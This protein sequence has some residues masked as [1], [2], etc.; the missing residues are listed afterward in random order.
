MGK[1]P[2]GPMTTDALGNTVSVAELAERAEAEAARAAARARREAKALAAS[3]DDRPSP[4][5][6]PAAASSSPAAA[7]AAVVSLEDQLRALVLKLDAGEKL[8]GKEKRLHAK[9][10]KDGRLP[11]VDEARRHLDDDDAAS[12]PCSSSSSSARKKKPPAALS[13]PEKWARALEAVSVHVRSGG[14]GDEDHPADVRSG[15][16]AA[17][18]VSGLDVSVRGVTLFDDAAFKILRGQKLALL[19]ANGSGKSTLVRL[20][21]AGRIRAHVA[22]VACVAQELEASDRSAFEA[23]VSCDPAAEALFEEERTIEREMEE[24][25]KLDV[26]GEEDGGPDEGD[27]AGG[28]GDT[29]TTTAPTTPPTTPPTF[30]SVGWWRLKASRLAEIGDAL[31]SR[32]AYAAESNARR[33]L[34]GLG[35]DDARQDAPLRSLS[36]GWRMRA[37][38]ATALFLKPGLL[39]LDEP[40]NHLDLP[41]TLWLARYLSSS[42]ETK[43]TS[44]LIVSHS[45]DFVAGCGAEVLFLDKFS[46]KITKHAGD[47]WNFLN[48]AEERHRLALKRYEAQ[49][50]QLREVQKKH[51]GLS[52]ERAAAKLTDTA[53]AGGG[54]KKHKGD[55]SDSG[56]GGSSLLEKPRE[57]AVSFHFPGAGDDR[58]TIAVLDAGFAGYDSD[59]AADS[60]SAATKKVGWMFRDLRFSVHSR[61]RLA[62]VGPNGCG[63]STLINLL[64]GK[65]APTSGEITHGRGLVV[66]R[67]DQHF[68]D[69]LGV[70]SDGDGSSTTTTDPPHPMSRPGGR[71]SATSFLENTFA[72]STQDAR[73]LLGRSGLESESHLAPL[74][75]LSGGQKARVVFA[76]LAA[77]RAHVLVMDEP[78]NHLD[79][80]SV[81]ALVEGLNAFEG[82]VVVSTHDPRVVEGME[83]ADV[84]VVGGGAGGDVGGSGGEAIFG[85]VRDLGRLGGFEKYR[86]AIEADVE[87]R[88]E[89]AEAK[90]AERREGRRRRGAE[91]SKLD[92]RSKTRR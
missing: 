22:D 7:P 47:V 60:D 13:L 6:A 27:P 38:L 79:I 72:L 2:K 80:E 66:G 84:W 56:G 70:A 1:K 33:I 63:K 51:P 35:F 88:V 61:T 71:V 46:K 81:E 48:G 42:P 67:Y 10:E 64:L 24:A 69:I 76:S 18:S 50:K 19:G 54:K 29:T 75:N 5:D 87:A 52:A 65:L 32:G 92:A 78:T 68:D 39:L 83:D 8:T 82:G 17:L 62:L 44:A 90:A 14:G 41:A 12:D 43:H 73:R 3:S 40:T 49:Q 25:E 21:A 20:I 91:K 77:T 85:G 45:A 23:L 4:A 86:A 59:A 36:G 53:R 16:G 11:S 9:A 31:Q 57:Y 55:D 15:G 74:A 58:P 28:G 34:T 26:V 37:A 89:A 30:G